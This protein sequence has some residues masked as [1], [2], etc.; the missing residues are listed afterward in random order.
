MNGP[1]LVTHKVTRVGIIPRYA[2]YE[3]E[4][5]WVE[6]PGFNFVH[7]VN[8]WDEKGGGRWCWWRRTSCRWSTCSR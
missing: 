3:S 5:K 7:S 6:V 1:S 8:A 4:M 2:T